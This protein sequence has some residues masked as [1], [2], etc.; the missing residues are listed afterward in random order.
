MPILCNEPTNTHCLPL[1]DVGGRCGGV[2][3]LLVYPSLAVCID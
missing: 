1:V 3:L 2:V